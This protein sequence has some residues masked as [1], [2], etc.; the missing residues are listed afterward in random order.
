[1]KWLR[2]CDQYCEEFIEFA[3]NILESSV[4]TDILES[5]AEF[6]NGKDVVV[7]D[8]CSL[9][10]EGGN[11]EIVGYVIHGEREFAFRVVSGNW[12]GTEVLGWEEN[13]S[14]RLLDRSGWY[15]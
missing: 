14:F 12:N 10:R 7:T 2:F 15:D 9:D 3:E 8:R 5:I 1:M 6:G 13:S 11:H 4:V